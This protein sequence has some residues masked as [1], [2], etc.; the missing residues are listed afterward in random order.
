MS[1]NTALGLL[2]LGAAAALRHREEVRRRPQIASLLGAVGILALGAS[3][4]AEY[5]LHSDLRLDRL[6]LQVLPHG[7]LAGPYPGRPS[8]PTALALTLISM[9]LLLYDCR[10]R[11]RVRPSEWLLFGAFATAFVALVGFA[12]GAG[13]LYRLA[14]APVTGVA[15]PT[16]VGLLL[17]S[18]G[19]LLE[20]PNAGVMCVM[21]SPGPGGVM[22]RRLV[23]PAIVAP[24][25]LGP[26]IMRAL[27]AMDVQDLPLTLAVVTIA[28]TAVT[29]LLLTITA[30]PLNRAHAV[31]ESSRA[32]IHDLVEQAPDGIF[33]ADSEGH[34]LDVNSAGCRL[35]GF[36]REEI[37]TKTISDVVSST[38]VER[39]QREMQKLRKGNATITEWSLTR[40]DGI[41]VP[42]E[43]S[44][45]ILADGRLQGFV[46][47]VSERIHAQERLRQ[48]QE[49]LELALWG[50]DLAAWDWNITTGDV[51]FNARWSEIRGFQPG[52]T[53]L[54]AHSW[55]AG[56]HPD[57]QP[58]VL[59]A[60]TEHCQGRTLE[61]ETEHRI[62]TK[63]G[64]WLW[65]LARGKVF[66]RDAQGLP[67]RMVGTELDITH[68]KHLEEQLR[69][70]LAQASGILSVSADAII[71]IDEAWRI[72]AFNE[73]AESIFGYRRAEMIG[74]SLD[75]L[76]PERF[77]AVHRQH[78]ARFAAGQGGSRRVGERGS[79]IFGLRKDGTEF[80]ADAAISNLQVNGTTILTVALRDITAEK[81]AQDRQR[82]L[83]EA[84]AILVST[85]DYDEILTSLARLA[86]REFADLCSVDVFEASGEIRRIQ[87]ITRDPSLQWACEILRAAPPDRSRPHQVWSILQTR[88]PILME[89][90]S[91]ETA[92]SFAQDNPDRLRAIRAIDPKSAIT[93][94]L[95]AHGQVIGMVGLVSSAPS[96]RYS[97]EDV[98]VA[99]ALALRAAFAI[100]NARLYGTAQR[101]LQARDEVLGI[102]AHDLRNP[103][104]SIVIHSSLLGQSKVRAGPLSLDPVA[105]IQR[106]AMR[107]NRMIQ[108]LLDV[109]CVEAG[110]LRVDRT[111]VP[112]SQVVHEAVQAQKAL[113][114]TIPLELRLELPQQLPEVWADHDRLLQ[115]FE[116]L[117][118]NAVKF[119]AP[120]GVIRIRATPKDG[121]VFFSVADT[122]TGIAAEALPHVFD[123]FW[124]AR[125]DKS[126]GAGL[127]LPIVKGIVEAHGGRIW[128]ESIPGRGTTFFFT[129][130]VAPREVGDSARAAP[131]P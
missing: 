25:V 16:A 12:Y 67:L 3:T 27:T 35:L 102:V 92:G 93:V 79:A 37:L 119:T 60:L 87:V 15:M 73:G 10:L 80:P 77:R 21:T 98:R 61:Y 56:V 69:V 116:N 59:K 128:V 101:A 40:K 28:M 91:P 83:A 81:R 86:V 32:H 57:D 82:L 90:L 89:C 54:H 26:T 121:E 113:A 103:L 20:R 30:T 23:L 22:L 127:G 111:P 118:G 131:V 108:D 71:S 24:L 96:R 125:Q 55:I 110:R 112:T 95:L 51:A 65:I 76:L 78:L 75:E 129:I 84:G 63:S 109:A 85:L 104:N 45:K 31:L 120:G 41:S 33:V 99:E 97:A 58:R 74:T 88:Q 19:L 42:V 7:P 4:L 5:A 6:L 49:R 18:L 53:L 8:P 62:C 13:P 44:A 2:V 34:Y 29:L 107:M 38:E 117:L 122:G 9:A 48:S 50:A 1:P 130:P 17:I 46:R 123:R 39:L 115:V 66:A 106:S 100:E 124:Q 14:H 68:R 114:A 126:R 52:E 105:A 94:P 43:V 64:E 11:A 70:S 36:T 47:D 72:T